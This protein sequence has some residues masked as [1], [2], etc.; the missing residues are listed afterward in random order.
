MSG[1]SVKLAVDIAGGNW[2]ECLIYAAAIAAFVIGVIGGLLAIEAVAARHVK[3]TFGA[4]AAIELVLLLAFLA[5]ARSPTE[6]MLGL[7]AAAMGVQ[8]A[9][10]R[11][12]GH[13]GVRTTVITGMLAQFARS[14]VLKSRDGTLLYGLIWVSFVSGGAAGAFLDYRYGPVALLL[15]IV[16]LAALICFDLLRPVMRPLSG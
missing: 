8:N 11:R 15:P 14:V 5:L 9:L 4:V 3:R 1:N 2:K 6:W 10:L 7:P 12:V 13:R 16:G